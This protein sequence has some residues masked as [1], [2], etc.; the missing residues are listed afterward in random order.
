MR[1]VKFA[2]ITAA[3]VSCGAVVAWAATPEEVVTQREDAM[4]TFGASVKTLTGF[5]RD[6]Q[7]SIDDVKAAT[8]KMKATSADLLVLFPE[9]TAV[10]IGKSAAKPEI[11]ANW[12]DFQT[13]VKANQDAIAAL[14]AAAQEGNA[15]KVKAAFP[16]VGQSCGACHET[17][18]VKKS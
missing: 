1:S 6:N 15:A 18:R 11:W 12:A 3:I 17:Y 5:V 9:G 14:D 13:K 2:V 4:K 8:A 16:A 10:G 7:G